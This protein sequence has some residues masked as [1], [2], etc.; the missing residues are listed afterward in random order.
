MSGVKNSLGNLITS[1][2]IY[3]IGFVSSVIVS[4]ILGPEDRGVYTYMLLLISFS[5]PILSFGFGSGVTYLVSSKKYLI[6]DIL[7]SII[8]I[9]VFI[10]ML[11]GT[12]ILL[13]WKLNVL[14]EAGS[15]I[16]PF[17]MMTLIGSIICSTIFFNL[18][19]ILIG[20]SYFSKL[21]LLTLLQG[22]LSPVLIFFFVGVLSLKLKG[23]ALNIFFVNAVLCVY[24]LKICLDKYKPDYRFNAVFL[25]ECVVYGFKGW[26]GDMA[27]RANV[28][29]DQIILGLTSSASF[30]GIYSVAVFL[31]E[32][33]W[34]VPDSVGPILFNKITAAENDEEKIKITYK[35]NRILL[36]ISFIL[37]VPLFIGVV[38]FI[39]PYGYGDKFIDARVPF[40]VLLPGSLLFIT[41]KVITKILSGSGHIAASSKGMIYGSL[42]SII[43][44][45]ILIPKYG[46]IGAAIASS[47][48]YF[49]VSV[50]CL[51]QYCKYFPLNYFD[52]FVIKRE[53]ISE[54]MMIYKKIL[55]I[56]S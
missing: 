29:L 36:F 19:R 47:L 35:A 33:I 31:V 22:L 12:S 18:S 39:L 56:K 16:L 27:G 37:A 44:Y 25:R 1:I 26:F 30:L 41:H 45:I 17:E 11:I 10:G 34:L 55:K 52:F 2:I 24:L 32:L 4:R 51:I 40:S 13:L 5:L 43:L 23:A 6:K 8:L 20:D 7:A 46:L 15:K 3:P 38:Y 42:F 49:A 53:D 48:G 9:S 28:R 14:G 54:L 50:S 21:N